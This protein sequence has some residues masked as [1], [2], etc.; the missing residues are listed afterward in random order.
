MSDFAAAAN[1]LS[2]LVAL[3]LHWPPDQFWHATPHEVE[4]IF[5]AWQDMQAGEGGAAV[6]PPDADTL[7][8]LR[9]AFPDYS[10]R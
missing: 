9:R 10:I 4:T 1:R 8:A 2:G 6:T 7:A 3:L 5:H